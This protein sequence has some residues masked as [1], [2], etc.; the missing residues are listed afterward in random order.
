[1]VVLLLEGAIDSRSCGVCKS[2]V[3]ADLS[4][5]PANPSVPHALM[6]HYWMKMT[7]ILD[8]E[9]DN[10][11]RN[12]EGPKENSN[13]EYKNITD[14]RY[15]MH[16]LPSKRFIQKQQLYRDAPSANCIPIAGESAN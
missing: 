13:K 4:Y 2:I 9:S 1:M 14:W 7:Y 15:C 16:R 3:G 11:L 5:M 8:V 6:H 10:V 12:G